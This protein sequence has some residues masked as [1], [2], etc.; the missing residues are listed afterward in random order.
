MGKTI[1][2]PILPNNLEKIT[3][4]TSFGL[5]KFLI[6]HYSFH[7]LLQRCFNLQNHLQHVKIGAKSC[8]IGLQQLLTNFL[9]QITSKEKMISMMINATFC[10]FFPLLVH[11][12]MNAIKYTYILKH[13]SSICVV[14]DVKKNLSSIVFPICLQIE[15]LCV[16]TS[17]TWS[18]HALNCIDKIYTFQ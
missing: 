6:G 1:T 17:T 15:A 12:R 4:S 11:N 16:I 3:S 7:Q 5:F 13:N 2:W 8:F 10:Q 14:F 9:Y 18:L